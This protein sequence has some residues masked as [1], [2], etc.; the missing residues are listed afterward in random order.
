MLALYLMMAAAHH[1]NTYSGDQDGEN[2]IK[3]LNPKQ[4]NTSQQYRKNG[5]V[6]AD[7]RYHAEK[8]RQQSHCK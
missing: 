4:R 6:Y 1:K 2:R 5:Y 8:H 3:L 7:A